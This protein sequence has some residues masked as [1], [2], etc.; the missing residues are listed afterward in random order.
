MKAYRLIAIVLVLFL[1]YS[2]K[3]AMVS[4]GFVCL[5]HNIHHFND[6]NELVECFDLKFNDLNDYYIYS[7][8][9]NYNNNFFWVKNTLQNE[10]ENKIV[11]DVISKINLYFPGSLKYSWNFN[12]MSLPVKFRTFVLKNNKHSGQMIVIGIVKKADLKPK[13]LIY[14]LPLEYKMDVIG[15]DKKD[16]KFLK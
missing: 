8:K 11:D 15:K 5:E 16:L 1:V 4:K 10:V 2:C 6:K 3:S 13:R 7:A 9:G 12:Q 14:Y